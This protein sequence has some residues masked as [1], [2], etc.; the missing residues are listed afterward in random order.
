MIYTTK[1]SYSCSCR[2]QHSE[3]TGCPPDRASPELQFFLLTLVGGS[4]SY[5]AS[6]VDVGAQ[7][8]NNHFFLKTLETIRSPLYKT[9]H[10][11]CFSCCIWLSCVLAEVILWADFK[12]KFSKCFLCCLVQLVQL[13][14]ALAGATILLP[15]RC[16]FSQSRNL[17]SPPALSSFL[18]STVALVIP[19]VL[20]F[21]R[22]HV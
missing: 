13:A 1:K 21:G 19:S 2:W 11:K 5:V 4:A 7:D 17:F 20:L 8:R 3:P 15:D 9:V 22:L 6:L 18:S 14:A 16:I 12:P 10:L